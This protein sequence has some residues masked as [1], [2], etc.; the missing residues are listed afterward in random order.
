MARF[1]RIMLIAAN[2]IVGLCLVLGAL[3]GYADPRSMPLLSLFVLAFPLTVF[4]MLIIL[5]CDFV[6]MRMWA[7]GAT[8]AMMLAFPAI[9]QI[10]PANGSSHVLTEAERRNS[11]TLMTYNVLSFW[12]VSG[13]YPLNY[14]PTVAEILADNPDIACLQE[15]YAFER[16]DRVQLSGTQLDTVYAQYPYV[17]FDR[18]A[19]M[20]ILSKF[21]IQHIENPMSADAETSDVS[22]FRADVKGNPVTV[23]AVHLASLSLSGDERTGFRPSIVE[24]ITGAAKARAAQADTL[25]ALIRRIAP[26]GDVIVCGDFNDVPGC[27]S[28][29]TL[30][31]DGFRS[32]NAMVG[33][34]YMPTYNAYRIL[35][36]I[37][38]ILYRGQLR[39]RL[40]QRGAKRNSDH[41]SVSATFVAAE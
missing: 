24:K 11:F 9:L 36:N 10:F 4:L 34:K 21:P 31:A 20:T 33:H 30:Q 23:F 13:K 3:G 39:P 38:H 22:I 29:R 41:Y 2:I 5:V 7:V 35:V 1:L 25:A 12:N 28:L 18:K 37:D 17:R 40:I 8:L 16:M 26:S 14:N 6:W 15:T 32:V 27:Y 19:S